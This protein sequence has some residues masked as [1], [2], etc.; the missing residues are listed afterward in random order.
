[1]RDHEIR[2]LQPLLDAVSSRNDIRLLGPSRAEDRAP[3]VALD[4]GRPAA[5]VAEQLAK[6]GINCGGGDFYAVRPLR[7]M[8]VDPAQGVLRLSFVHYTTEAE[9]TRAIEALDAVL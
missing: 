6:H 5:P 8:G 1:M 4:L 9:V 2:L 7:A 3:T